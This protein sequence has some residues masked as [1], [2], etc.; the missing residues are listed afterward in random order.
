MQVVATEG[1][2]RL[3]DALH[4]ICEAGANVL[5]RAEQ[6]RYP[7]TAWLPGRRADHLVLRDGALEAGAPTGRDT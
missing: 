1:R 3:G 4:R 7:A 5:D 2:A 6:E